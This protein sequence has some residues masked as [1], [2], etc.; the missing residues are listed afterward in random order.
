M[1][2]G[3][4]VSWPYQPSGLAYLQVLNILFQLFNFLGLVIKVLLVLHD[5]LVRGCFFKFVLK[6]AI[7]LPPFSF[8]APSQFPT[9]P[10]SSLTPTLRGL[11]G[12][13][14]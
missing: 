10:V 7:L 2:L 3:F 6:E 11:S 12:F 8:L 9:G 5:T 14:V 4:R 13:R 1:V